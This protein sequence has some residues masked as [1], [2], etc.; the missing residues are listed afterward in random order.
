MP[1]APPLITPVRLTRFPLAPE[2]MLARPGLTDHGPL[3]VKPAGLPTRFKLVATGRI[4]ELVMVIGSVPSITS[5]QPL[6]LVE[7]IAP[8]PK[9]AL[10]LK[11][12][13]PLNE[14]PE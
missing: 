4:K 3:K 12:M 5:A 8:V 6:P 2:P 10:L 9:E 1:P 7:V 13:M 14:A 11:L